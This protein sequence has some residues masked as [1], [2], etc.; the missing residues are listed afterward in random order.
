[1]VC[2]L[3]ISYLSRS[4]AGRWGTTVDFTTSFF[5]SSRFSAF[6]SSIF[7]SRPVH[8]LKL[9]FH[10]FLCLCLS[11]YEF[12]KQTQ[13]FGRPGYGLT[14]LFTRIKVNVSRSLSQPRAALPGHC[15]LS[16]AGV[17]PQLYHLSPHRPHQPLFS[18]AVWLCPPVSRCLSVFVS[19]RPHLLLSGCPPVCWRL[20]VFVCLCF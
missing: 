1:M 16:S 4:L 15:A 5:H 14:S 19:H 2:F 7:H 20:S 18:S 9:S 8:S 3:S 13:E 17:D 6:R 12:V 11:V 10:P